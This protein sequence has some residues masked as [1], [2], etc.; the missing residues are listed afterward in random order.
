MHL[1]EFLSKKIKSW[2]PIGEANTALKYRSSIAEKWF[3]VLYDLVSNASWILLA[4]S[5][6]DD[7]Y[8]SINKLTEK[9]KR[10]LAKHRKIQCSYQHELA[11]LT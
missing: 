2:F 5:T 1:A 3:G 11:I 8:T 7:M 4:K 6:A 9:L 10:Q